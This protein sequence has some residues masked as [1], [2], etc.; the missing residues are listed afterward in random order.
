MTTTRSDIETAVTLDERL[1]ELVQ[2]RSLADAA[3]EIIEQGLRD[4]LNLDRVLALLFPLLGSHLQACRAW[5]R[6][7]DDNLKRKD[8]YW[9]EDDDLLWPVDLSHLEERT[10]GGEHVAEVV[11]GH[12]VVACKIDV[13]GEDFGTAALCVA[14]PLD[15]PE[16]E[17]RARLLT[18]WCEQLDNHLASIAQARR[19]HHAVT[20]LSEAL[21]DTVLSD[22]IEKALAV[23]AE[24][25]RYD[26]LLLVYRHDEDSEGGTAA[27]WIVKD[28]KLIYDSRGQTD[29]EVDAFMR[30]HAMRLLLHDETNAVAARFGLGTFREEVMINGVK[31]TRI[32][33]RVLVSNRSGSDFSTIERD[34]LER[35]ADF[36]RQ[37]IVDF[38]REWR[39]LSLAFPRTTVSRLLN[40]D[41]YVERYLRPRERDVAIMY[42]D[43]S[44]F[45]R[46]SE[47]VLR[48][49][50]LIGTLVDTWSNH[51][52]EMIWGSDG[53]FD[54][55]VGDCIIGLWGPPFF[56]MSPQE[57][58]RQA[59]LAAIEVR[60]FTRSLTQSE[61]LPQLRELDQPLTVSTGL[62]YC[63]LFVGLFGPNENYT[64]FASG[65]NNAA[66]LQGVAARDE[67]L[68]MDNMCQVLGSR[69]EFSEEKAAQVK[70]VAEP[71]RFRSLLGVH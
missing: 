29:P 54:K 17:Q 68:C 49:P 69:G 65:M 5:V 66:R 52:V 36:L 23:L 37:R 11:D 33:G 42:C 43:I 55:M 32:V 46:V 44:G 1:E 3:D 16:L 50:A 71:L 28:R 40:E 13:A 7:F 48:T 53:V 62:N 12:S 30:T 9:S 57:A 25:V 27:Y 60:A 10:R 21:R 63:P 64:G 34:L 22:G 47:Q 4:Q 2:L 35:F 6:T 51:V 56:E 58:C 18:V 31:D 15:G 67:I 38:N 20:A 26:H 8:F 24:H 70:N 19:K 45:T 39:H 41:N 59:A 61:L 14:E